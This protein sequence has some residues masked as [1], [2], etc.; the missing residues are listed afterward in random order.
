MGGWKTQLLPDIRKKYPTELGKTITKYCEP[1]IGGGSV[2]PDILSKKYK[3]CELVLDA[4]S[5][6][7][8]QIAASN[9]NNEQER[10]I[11]S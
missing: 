3:K 5:I 2:L 10:W 1:F 7:G 8:R 11:E 6:S 4:P 9:R